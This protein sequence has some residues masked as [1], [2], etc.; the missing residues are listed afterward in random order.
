MLQ[1][2]NENEKSF[3]T[4]ECKFLWHAHILEYQSGNLLIY[5]LLVTF[6]FLNVLIDLFEKYCLRKSS[7]SH[8]KQI[9]R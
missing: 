5:D 9:E 1:I 8:R 4:N 3:E 7:S 2:N 6:G